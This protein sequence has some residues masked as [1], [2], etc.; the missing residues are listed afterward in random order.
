M[1]FPALSTVP[2]PPHATPPLRAL[3]AI[4]AGGE[5][6]RFGS[7]KGLASIGGAP[8]VERVREALAAA[9]THPVIITHLPELATLPGL[10]AR[11][12]ATHAGGP[13]AGIETALA[14]AEERGLPG[15][16]CVAC[17]MPFLS[18]A[19]LCEIARAGL[20]SGALALAP[21]SGARAGFEPL[22]AWYSTAALA[23]VRAALERG[24]RK[25]TRVVEELRAARL[26]IARVAAHGDPAVLFLNVNTPAG[27]REAEEIAM[28]AGSTG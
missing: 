11:P 9:V 15:A 7:V 26:P 17:D 13:L 24:E 10:P 25:V 22:C 3:G 1:T 27:R 6:S 19:L 21:E 18:G 20:A 2:A 16:L 4:L 23:T 14:W 12:D 28:R 8:L 5:S